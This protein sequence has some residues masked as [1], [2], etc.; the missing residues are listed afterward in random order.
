MLE[1]MSLTP[2]IVMVIYILVEIL[3]ITVLKKYP[4]YKA[5][6]PI[7]CAF[8]GAGIGILLFFFVPSAIGEDNIISA[9]TNGA[10]S[11]FATTGCNQI[12]KQMRKFRDE[13]NNEDIQPISSMNTTVTATVEVVDPMSPAIDDEGADA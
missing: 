9:L 4:K 1:Y 11:G 13:D 3:K 8:I 2:F 10:F 5:A 6:L 12:Y 7:I